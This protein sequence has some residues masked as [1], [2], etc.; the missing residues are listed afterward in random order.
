MLSKHQLATAQAIDNSGLVQFRSWSSVAW[1]VQL[2]RC[3][4]LHQF[5]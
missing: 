5:N 2:V 3:R 4:W 1:A